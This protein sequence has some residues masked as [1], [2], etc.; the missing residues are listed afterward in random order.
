MV[1]T[2]G[3]LG[4][5]LVKNWESKHATDIG[6]AFAKMQLKMLTFK[7]LK[8]AETQN[9]RILNYE[10]FHYPHIHSLDLTNFH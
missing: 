2:G 10:I 3:H 9:F 5:T 4:Y 6:R 8:A 1:S 7:I